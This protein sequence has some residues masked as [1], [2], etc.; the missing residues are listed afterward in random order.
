MEYDG[1][2]SVCRIFSDFAKAFGCVNHQILLTKL[3]HYGFRKKAHDLLNSYLT[4]QLHCT[5]YK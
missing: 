2:S 4:Y 5:T 3:E 1:N